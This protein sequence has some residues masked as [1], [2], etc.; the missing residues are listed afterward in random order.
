MPAEAKEA[1]AALFPR[2]IEVLAAL[3]DGDDPALALKATEIILDRRLG[4][5]VQATVA[6]V[7]TN[8]S[9]LDST[10]AAA[11]LKALL[12]EARH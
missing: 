6:N 7:T 10:D 2:A 8:G 12:D 4:K 1:F 3:V 11:R 5:A 9:Q